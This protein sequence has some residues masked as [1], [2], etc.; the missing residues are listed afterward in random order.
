MQP[1]AFDDDGVRHTCRTCGTVRI[2][3]FCKGISICIT[4]LSRICIAVP[5]EQQRQQQRQRTAAQQQ[6]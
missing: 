4:A 5:R 1:M 6:E 2:E 3:R